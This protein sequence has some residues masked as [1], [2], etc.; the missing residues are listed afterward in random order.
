M[1]IATP[2][3]RC[4]SSRRP[5][6]PQS[7]YGCDTSSWHM[8]L[9][10]IH[11]HRDNQYHKQSLFQKEQSYSI[12]IHPIGTPAAVKRQ[13]SER[14][15]ESTSQTTQ[16]SNLYS[17]SQFS[18]RMVGSWLLYFVGPIGL[19]NSDD[20]CRLF[21]RTP[22]GGLSTFLQALCWVLCLSLTGALRW[23]FETRTSYKKSW[24]WSFV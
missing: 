1:I 12:L 17:C 24:C 21:W 11:R 23:G 13:Q 16:W 9:E 18:L 22:C 8:V 6:F 19:C 5:V 15:C 10:T 7:W 3:L 20:F 14:L 2:R 4:T